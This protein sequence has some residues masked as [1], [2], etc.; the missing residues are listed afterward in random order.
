M[1]IVL[2]IPHDKRIYRTWN[3]SLVR[4]VRPDVNVASQSSLDTGKTR[5][6]VVGK[7]TAF[8]TNA[9]KCDPFLPSSNRV[10]LFEEPEVEIQ[11]DV[12]FAVDKS[13]PSTATL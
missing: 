1:Q 4:F 2:V 5:R 13:V 7:F 6:R 11:R 12:H 8:A 9:N 10:R 3:R